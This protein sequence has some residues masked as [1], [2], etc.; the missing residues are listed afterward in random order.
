MFSQKFRYFFPKLIK[1]SKVRIFQIHSQESDVSH[2]ERLKYKDFPN[3]SLPQKG[4]TK[5]FGRNFKTI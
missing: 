3:Q 1:E 4:H 5:V 2:N